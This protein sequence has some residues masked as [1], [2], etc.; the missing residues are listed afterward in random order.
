MTEVVYCHSL[1]T[2]I[3]LFIY[4]DKGAVNVQPNYLLQ[5][6]L[7]C[8]PGGLLTISVEKSPLSRASLALLLCT[9]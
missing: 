2:E 9:L 6:N 3:D 8:V 7:F 1:N 5:L 4:E